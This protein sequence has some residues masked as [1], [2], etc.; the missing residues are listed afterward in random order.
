[1]KL[2][3]DLARWL[4]QRGQTAS[5]SRATPASES[6]DRTSMADFVRILRMH[7]EEASRRNYPN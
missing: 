5:E 6:G 2:I 3:I 7:D 4:W 1:M